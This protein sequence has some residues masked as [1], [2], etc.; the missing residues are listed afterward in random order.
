M[1]YK[2]Y[3]LKNKH[4]NQIFDEF[5]KIIINCRQKFKLVEPF[6]FTENTNTGFIQAACARLDIVAFREYRTKQLIKG[7]VHNARGDL[8]IFIDE[9]NIFRVEAKQLTAFEIQTQR[10]I[11]EIQHRINKNLAQIEQYSKAQMKKIKNDKYL[12][13]I[14]SVPRFLTSKI[15]DEDQLL[16]EWNKLIDTIKEKFYTP[17]S[18]IIS[19]RNQYQNVYF[20]DERG[21]KTGYPGIIIFGDVIDY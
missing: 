9:N 8:F 7:E 5:Y 17:N 21:K 20:Q 1:E 10:H 13:L 4:L 12:S 11:N 6:M 18:F 19:L 16:E 3:D 14:Y 15:S 2:K